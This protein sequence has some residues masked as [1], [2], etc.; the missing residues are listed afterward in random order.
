MTCQVCGF[1]LGTGLMVRMSWGDRTGDVIDCPVCV[2]WHDAQ[3]IL[4]KATQ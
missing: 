1:Q 3:S 2:A 4:R